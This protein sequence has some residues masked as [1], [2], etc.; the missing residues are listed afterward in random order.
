MGKYGRV[1]VEAIRGRSALQMDKRC[2]RMAVQ[3]VRTGPKLWT[4]LLLHSESVDQRRRAGEASQKTN[5][6]YIIGLFVDL[7]NP[8]HQQVFA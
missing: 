6:F 8:S 3:V 4:P 5:V 1:D 2:E 7:S